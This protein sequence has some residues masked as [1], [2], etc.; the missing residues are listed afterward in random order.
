M[1]QQTCS[2][3]L[4]PSPPHPTP[5]SSQCFRC[6]FQ[7]IPPGPH[8]LLV[9]SCAAEP[10]QLVEALMARGQ[11][12]SGSELVHLLTLGPA[13]C[14]EPSARWAGCGIAGGCLPE[15]CAAHCPSELPAEGVRCGYARVS[16]PLPMA[17]LR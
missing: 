9:G 1:V 7:A 15:C 8:R 17:L 10:T 4:P 2:R 5:P 13:P 16:P 12:L 3:P 14:A 6:I 11:Q